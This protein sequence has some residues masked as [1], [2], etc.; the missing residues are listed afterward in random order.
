MSHVEIRRGYLP[1]GTYGDLYVNG[2]FVCHTVERPW[3]DNK[4]N[5]SCIPE[6]AYQLEAYKSPRFGDCF[7]VSGGDDDQRIEKF[8][9]NNG[10]RWGILIHPANTPSQLAG[11]IAPV[12]RFSTGLGDELGGIRSK[13]T[14]DQLKKALGNNRVIKITAKTYQ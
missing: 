3:L 12:E 11:C 8:K 10:K 6:G 2:R 13:R 14:F 1:G 7:I 5:I 4:P 9:N